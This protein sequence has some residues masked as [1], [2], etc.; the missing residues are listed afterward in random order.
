[1]NS[2]RIGCIGERELAA[3]LREYGFTNAHRC[4][5]FKGGEDSPDVA[6]FPDIHI[7]CKR[8]EKLNIE[9]AMEQAR[10]DCGSKAPAVF[11]R[12]N[13]R[14]WMVTMLLSDWIRLY[15]EGGADEH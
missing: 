7:E 11:H 8:V 13:R 15:K 14:P 1:M 12:R 5:Q 9:T 2:K 6:C 10:H 4:Q 3:I